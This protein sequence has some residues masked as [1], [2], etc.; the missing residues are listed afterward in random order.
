M[1]DTIVVDVEGVSGA[2][3]LRLLVAAI[4]VRGRRADAAFDVGNEGV[5]GW[6]TGVELGRSRGG[7]AGGEDW[8]GDE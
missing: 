4:G 1:R 5:E 6:K 3:G 2:E 8:G 7:E